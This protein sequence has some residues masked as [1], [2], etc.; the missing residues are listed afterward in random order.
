[1]KAVGGSAALVA[2]TLGFVFGACGA[3]VPAVGTGDSGG[4]NEV[5]AQH[6]DA[7]AEPT[8]DAEALPDV[9]DASGED[10]LPIDLPTKVV[11][12]LSAKP[13][14][15]DQCIPTTF[16]GFPYPA[17]E[18]TYNGGLRVKVANPPAERVAAWIVDSARLIDVVASL[19]TRD[20]GGY[21]SALVVIA[22]N[23][24]GQSSRIFPLF[25]QVDEGTVYTFDRGVTKTCSTGC[26]CRINSTSRQVY[27]AYAAAALGEN[28]A[29]CLQ[30]YG[31]TMF[32]DAWA[33]KCLANHVVSYRRNRNEMFLARA[34]CANVAM[35]AKFP[36][37]AL[38]TPAEIVAALKVY[39]PP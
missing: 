16:P 19:Q 20:P 30:N 11:A 27:C 12:K 10:P 24:M 29:S 13:Y 38:P 28:E 7:H 21:E 3:E 39:F 17:Q 36:N 23:V 2:G 32:T 6:V 34:H 26:Y 18:C 22:A 8:R 4:I 35:K 33:D 14:V 5:D 31:T 9:L 25:G 1:V 15:E 37:P